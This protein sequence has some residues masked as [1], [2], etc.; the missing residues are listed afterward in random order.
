[1]QALAAQAAAAH[2]TALAQKA[3]REAFAARE[4]IETQQ[5]ARNISSDGLG[6]GRHRREI[7]FS[8]CKEIF[9]RSAEPCLGRF[10]LKA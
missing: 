7:T 6:Y 2:I 10:Y 4:A 3:R 8:L 5:L 9:G 1:M